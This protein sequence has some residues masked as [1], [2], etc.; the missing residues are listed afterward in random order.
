MEKYTKFTEKYGEGTFH[1]PIDISK[2][3]D[4][5][6]FWMLP[7]ILEL[8]DRVGVSSYMDGFFMDFESSRLCGLAK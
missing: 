5:D 3:S 4:Y 6:Q 7:E 8:L 2:I 1:H